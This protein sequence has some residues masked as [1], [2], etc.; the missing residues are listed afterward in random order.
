VARRPRTLAS[1]FATAAQ[2]QA[3][4][5]YRPQASPHGFAIYRPK[6][7]GVTGTDEP[8]YAALTDAFWTDV[9]SHEPAAAAWNTH[10]DQTL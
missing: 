3:G 10:L 7:L 9:E 2:H 5:P 8:D 4:H 1:T 6:F